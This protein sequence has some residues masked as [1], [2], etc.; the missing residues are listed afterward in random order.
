MRGRREDLRWER[1]ADLEGLGGA[2]EGTWEE[3]KEG[4]GIVV[5]GL[6]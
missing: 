4:E 2:G 5:K 1:R 3:E 6:R